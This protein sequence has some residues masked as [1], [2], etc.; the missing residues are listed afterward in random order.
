MPNFCIF[1]DK[2][3]ITEDIKKYKEAG[4][5]HIVFSIA[6][7]DKIYIEETIKKFAFEIANN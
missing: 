5:E 4:V 3:T 1:Q 2:L 7:E 6:S